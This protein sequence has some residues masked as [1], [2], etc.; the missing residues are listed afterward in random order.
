[1][2]SGFVL[3]VLAL[4]G[5]S[6]LAQEGTESRN[7]NKEA[8]AKAAKKA[9][10]LK[11]Y[12]FKATV[13]IEGSP[14]P[15]EPMEFDG[16]V[17][18][19][20]SHIR[21][22]VMGNEMEAYRKG[23]RTI[24]RNAD[25]DWEEVEKEGPMGALNRGLKP[26]HEQLKDFEKKLKDGIEKKGTEKVEGEDCDVYEG[27]LTEKAIRSLMRDRAGI[28]EQAEVSGK[29]RVWI[30]GEGNVRQVET[31]IA[32][33][34]ELQGNPLEMT[35]TGRTTLSKFNDTRIETPAEV[36]KLLGDEKQEVPGEGR[37]EEGGEY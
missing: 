4:F 28:L 29:A 32:I 13:Q 12:T 17:Q 35:V 33:A 34:M 7:G 21:G 10:E 6:A 23:G 20:L 2:R 22:E 15:I 8:V 14:V 19:D 26:P 25:G 16:A 36:R 27:E 9:S 1:M 37:A 24:V 30:D 3:I 18:G 11:S 5:G 31:V